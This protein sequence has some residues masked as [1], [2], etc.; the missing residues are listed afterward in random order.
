MVVRRGACRAT[1]LMPVFVF[2]VFRLAESVARL[3][4]I[5]RSLKNACDGYTVLVPL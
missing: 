4:S 3:H 5:L 1:S 2:T